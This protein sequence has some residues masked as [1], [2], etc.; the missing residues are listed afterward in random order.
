MR[1]YPHMFSS[2]A[3]KQMHLA[4]CVIGCI[5]LHVCVC[6]CGPCIWHAVHVYGIRLCVCV[7]AWLLS[8]IWGPA[9]RTLCFK[10]SWARRSVAS[11][12]IIAFCPSQLVTAVPT[13]RRILQASASQQYT[14]P[15]RHATN[16]LLHPYFYPPPPPCATEDTL[17]NNIPTPP[18]PPLRKLKKC[19]NG[20]GLS[21]PSTERFHL[22][23]SRQ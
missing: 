12:H 1:I 15:A 2:L 23:V 17:H 3:C 9:S 19:C 4:S 7:C 20:A 8:R 16:H 11:P 5:H 14:D 22:W 21:S 18:P 6:V 13:R 10:S